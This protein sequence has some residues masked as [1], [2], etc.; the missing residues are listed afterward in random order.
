MNI[1]IFLQL[2]L[3]NYVLEENVNITNLEIQELEPKIQD[4]GKK[5]EER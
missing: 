5:F 2:R 4:L 1:Y 3:N